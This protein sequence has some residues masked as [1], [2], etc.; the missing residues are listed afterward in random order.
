VFETMRY[1]NPHFY[2]TLQ[3]GVCPQ[4]LNSCTD[5]CFGNESVRGGRD[6]PFDLVVAK[7]FA[8]SLLA[9]N[10]DDGQAVEH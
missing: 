7:F 3:E 4:L 10:V 5:L 6:E 8:V 9:N 1:T 2:F